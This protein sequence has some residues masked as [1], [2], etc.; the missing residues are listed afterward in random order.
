S[1]ADVE[2]MLQLAYLQMTQPRRDQALFDVFIDKQQEQARNALARPDAVLVDTM[3]TTLYGNHPRV[4][5]TPRPEELDGI[6]L[7]RV[8]EMHKE[9]LS[10][11]YGMTFV[12]VG[13]FELAKIK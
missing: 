9:R 2:T 10:S 3:R 7:D 5:L 8:M 4:A 1:S 12:F 13:S 11:A 6:R